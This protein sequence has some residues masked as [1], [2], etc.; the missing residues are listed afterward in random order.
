MGT[1]SNAT[2]HFVDQYA[3]FKATLPGMDLPWLRRDRDAAGRRFAELG[4]PTTRD[5]DWKYTRVSHL[6]SHPVDFARP[7]ATE[8]MHPTVEGWLLAGCQRLAFVDA[9][10]DLALSRRGTLPD[11]AV[12]DS[13][14]N[15]LAT[16]PEHLA[17]WFREPA[18]E[19]ADHGVVGIA[20]H[21]VAGIADHGFV[22]LAAAA[23]SDGA[24]IELPAG[25]IVD[26]PLH[27]LHVAATGD[28]ALCARHLVCLGD[29]A[30][31]TIV[32][33]H[34]GS[35]DA[36]YL[37]DSLTDIVLGEGAVLT[38]VMLQEAGPRATHIAELRVEQAAGSRL[39]A[40][41][42]ALG[43]R[44]SRTGITTRLAGEGA[45]ATLD[46]LYLADGRRHVDHH[47]TIDH[48]APGGKSRER[49]RGIV[50]G[51]ARAVFNGRVI[52]RP[53]AQR[54][55][56]AQTN[57]NLLLSAQAEVDT[58][59]QLEIWADDVQCSHGATVGQLDDAALFYLQSRG[60]PAATARALLIRAFADEIVAALQPPVIRGYVD[61]RLRALLPDAE[62]PR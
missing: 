46:G 21:G 31:A 6:D 39:E 45:Q 14:A 34:V 15:V 40:T 47:T 35:G 1:T 54:S 60:I 62:A 49:F 20:D 9:R 26:E 32:E 12:V 10:L 55:D 41:S 18:G 29:G 36:A 50:D 19:V 51:A 24:C 33:H 28:A 43:A 4:L 27:L 42:I 48:A 59:P 13:L 37:D 52:V 22:A 58:K 30:R 3:R 11:G 2:E 61:Q 8:A 53:D 56:A 5:E 16:A 17:H 38:W 44:L 25:A 57:R 23:W 7:E